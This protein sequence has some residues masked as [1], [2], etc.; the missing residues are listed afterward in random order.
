L[1][2]A[3]TAKR[4]KLAEKTGERR[5]RGQKKDQ[6]ASNMRGTWRRDQQNRGESP[7]SAGLLSPMM[8][9]MTVVVM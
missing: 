7:P 1:K 5:E 9:A 4:R 6:I 8:L 3:L 2:N